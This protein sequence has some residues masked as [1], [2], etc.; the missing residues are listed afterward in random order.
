MEFENSFDYMKS[1][2]N[3]NDNPE[4]YLFKSHM[5]IDEKLAALN[6]AD[7][8]GMLYDELRINEDY[9]MDDLYFSPHTTITKF[10]EGGGYFHASMTHHYDNEGSD[11][12]EEFHDVFVN[13]DTENITII[14][15]DYSAGDEDYSLEYQN[16]L[17]ALMIEHNLDL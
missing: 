7:I 1:I 4:K 3:K 15:K 6:R 16:N 17:Y 11:F 8:E 12:S 5:T 10:R 13:P 2:E 9:S 14:H